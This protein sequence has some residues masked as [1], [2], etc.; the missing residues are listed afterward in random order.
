MLYETLVSLPTNLILY[1]FFDK[2]NSFKNIGNIINSPFL[3]FK[4]FRRI[5]QVDF[6]C[7]GTLYYFDESFCKL[8]QTIIDSIFLYSEDLV[9]RYISMN[10]A[11]RRSVRNRVCRLWVLSVQLSNICEHFIWQATDREH[12][13]A[14]WTLVR[15]KWDPDIL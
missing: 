14:T 6:L 7:R 1:R 3:H 12:R 8:T 15:V 10:Y 5:I 13:W 11:A 2:A 4:H 9:A